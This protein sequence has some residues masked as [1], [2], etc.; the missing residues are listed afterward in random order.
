MDL[1]YID[2]DQIH[3]EKSVCSTFRTNL[4]KIHMENCQVEDCNSKTLIFS[5]S[6]AN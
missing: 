3:F 4:V 1:C 5:P 6:L 2:K